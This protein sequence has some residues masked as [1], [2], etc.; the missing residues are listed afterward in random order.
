MTIQMDP[1]GDPV[2]THPIQIG[3][4][5]VLNRIR[6]DSSG[7]LITQNANFAIGQF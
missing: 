5:F 7:V 1:L 2:T 3:W 6:I 4:I